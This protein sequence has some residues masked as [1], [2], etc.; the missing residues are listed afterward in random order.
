MKLLDRNEVN[1]RLAGEKKLAVDQ[2]VALARKVDALRQTASEEETKL[3]KFRTEAVKGLH[4]EIEKLAGQKRALLEEIAVATEELKARRAPLDSEW[5][6]C[7]QLELEVFEKQGQVD[8]KDRQLEAKAQELKT[9][10]ASMALRLRQISI[11]E[12]SASELKKESERTLA[13]AKEVLAK[14][15]QESA[16]AEKKLGGFR[17]QASQ[18]EAAL[19][20]REREAKMKEERLN[21]RERELNRRETVLNDRY[22]TLLRQEK[23]NNG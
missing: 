12:G 1:A 3:T 14:S 10:E 4:E 7:R 20:V 2:G 11:D 6:R 23:R 19:A 8:A 22:Q 18:R 13:E 21:A 16:T 17:I 15:N 9:L 5:N